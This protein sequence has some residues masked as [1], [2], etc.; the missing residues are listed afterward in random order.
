MV[1]S[2]VYH[3][4]EHTVVA[5]M[6]HMGKIDKT[7]YHALVRCYDGTFAS[8][9]DANELGIEPMVIKEGACPGSVGTCGAG[10]GAV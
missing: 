9:L 1:R 7:A 4:Y 5:S 2:K 6:L 3:L 10:I 8:L